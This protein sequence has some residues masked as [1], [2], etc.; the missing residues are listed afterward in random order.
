MNSGAHL[1]GN[2]VASSPWSDPDRTTEVA[3]AFTA[4]CGN[5][6]KVTLI[7]IALHYA[8]DDKSQMD[9]F[10][11]L[12]QG[13]GPGTVG[14][15]GNLPRNIPSLPSDDAGAAVYP[16]AKYGEVKGLHHISL[17][18]AKG[19]QGATIISTQDKKN[20]LDEGTRPALVPVPQRN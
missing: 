17:A 13:L 20:R 18:V 19:P 4:V 11:S 8:D 10:N 15:S 6:N 14:R 9:L 16:L 1:V 2:V 5:Q 3:I 12:P 7:L